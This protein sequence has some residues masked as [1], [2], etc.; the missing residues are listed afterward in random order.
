MRNQD[1][2]IWSIKVHEKEVTGLV[3]S[4]K[5]KGMLSSSSGDGE[6]IIWNYAER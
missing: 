2:P 3:L 6:L 5:I 1:A 4:S